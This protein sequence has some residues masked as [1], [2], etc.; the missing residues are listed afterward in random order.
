[1]TGPL[2]L[3][4]DA[5]NPMNPVTKRQL[6]AVY[7]RRSN[8]IG[9]VSQSSGYPTGAII[10]RGSNSNGQY[11][12]FAD[13]TMFC[14][15]KTLTI[16]RSAGTYV[17]TLTLPAALLTIENAVCI[18]AVGEKQ[19]VF[20]DAV[21]TTYESNVVSTTQVKVRSSHNFGSTL[22]FFITYIVM[23]RWY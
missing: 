14:I 21:Y 23:G 11:V 4:G 20:G 19:T 8:I 1:M 6:E 22:P 13:G 15:G 7:Y 17:D 3:Y 16:S 2:T 10:E 5:T 12:K 18:A 9:T